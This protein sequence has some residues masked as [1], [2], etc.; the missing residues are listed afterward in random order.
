[1]GPSRIDRYL[2]SFI[3]DEVIGLNLEVTLRIQKTLASLLQ[4]VINTGF[5]LPNNRS[6]FKEEGK[7]I[8]NASSALLTLHSIF[9]RYNKVYSHIAFD[10]PETFHAWIEITYPISTFVIDRYISLT[11]IKICNSVC[12]GTY[13]KLADFSN[14]LLEKVSFEGSTLE[15]CTFMNSSL[16]SIGFSGTRIESCLFVQSIIKDSNCRNMIAKL[17]FFRLVDFESTILSYSFVDECDFDGSFMNYTLFDHSILLHTN[18]RNAKCNHCDFTYT[19][20]QSVS[21]ENAD[22]RNANFRGADLSSVNFRGADLTGAIL[23]GAILSKNISSKNNY[24]NSEANIT[25]DQ[26]LSCS[27]CKGV[28]G[29][30]KEHARAIKNNNLTNIGEFMQD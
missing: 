26:I 20:F 14:S 3:F 5:P 23:D 19:H 29:M 12:R 4:I 21:F 25:L 30:N 2:L 13:L 16:N 10:R 28:I 15:G 6:N 1:M 8:S 18:F 9:A 27:S 17:S 7:V 24:H 11:H 22:L